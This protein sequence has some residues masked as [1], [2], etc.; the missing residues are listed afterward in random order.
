[1]RSK[2]ASGSRVELSARPI[3]FRMCSSSLRRAEQQHTE[4][5][6]FGLQADADHGAQTLSEQHFAN[7]AEGLFF[8][9]RHPVGISAE[10]AQDD[11]P[12]KAGD[13][14]DE[15]I[16]EITFLDGGAEGIVQ[17]SDY[18]RCRTI[19]LAIVQNECASRDAHYVENAIQR[20]RQHFL[21]FAAGKAGSCQIQ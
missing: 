16:V 5:A 19:L 1:M 4:D 10:I 12:A 2:S 15:I 7:V 11:E 8:F 21:N 9:Q 17:A 18:D 13:E 14:L 3:S 20:L 6:I